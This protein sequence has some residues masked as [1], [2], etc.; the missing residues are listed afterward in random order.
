MTESM[1]AAGVDIYLWLS[2]LCQLI[3]SILL[4]LCNVKQFVE[5]VIIVGLNLHICMALKHNTVSS[6]T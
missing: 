5:D 1:L 3:N 4:T 2:P 6:Y